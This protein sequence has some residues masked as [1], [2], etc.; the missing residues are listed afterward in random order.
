MKLNRSPLSFPV[1][2]SLLQLVFVLPLAFQLVFQ[3]AS[4]LP[5]LSLAYFKKPSLK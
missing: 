1:L 5:H 4:L 3:Q 2:A